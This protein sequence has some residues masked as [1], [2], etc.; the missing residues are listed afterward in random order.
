MNI[1]TLAHSVILSALAALAGS[2]DVLAATRNHAP[3]TMVEVR[4]DPGA[5]VEQTLPAGYNGFVVVLE[6]AGTVGSS[7]AVVEAGQVAWLT[8]SDEASAVAFRAGEQ[9]F[10]ALLFA[11]HP[12]GEPVAARGP[13]VM[14]TAAELEQAYADFRAQRERFGL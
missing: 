10:R 13:F 3:V 4:L 7:A 9:G 1:R 2:T 11:G 6:G 5:A 8:R 14:N 12:L